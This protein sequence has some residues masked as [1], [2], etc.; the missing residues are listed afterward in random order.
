MLSRV[1]PRIFTCGEI[2]TLQLATSILLSEGHMN[3]CCLVLMMMVL[4]LSG[5]EPSH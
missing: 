1:T 3:A 4:D 2:G 5:L